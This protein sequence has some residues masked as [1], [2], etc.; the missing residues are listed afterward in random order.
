MEQEAKDRL[1]DNVKLLPKMASA[2]MMSLAGVLG[3]IWF[4]LPPEQ[5]LDLIKNSPLPP[6]AYPIAMTA[7]A[8]LARV[9]PQ[10]A[11]RPPPADAADTQPLYPEPKG[12]AS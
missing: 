1:A 11:F 6:W 7:I 10:K 3:A 9:W 5:Q 12:P 8:V 4:A 2:W